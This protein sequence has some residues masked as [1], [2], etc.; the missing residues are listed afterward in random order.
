MASD[1]PPVRDEGVP[2]HEVPYRAGGPQGSLPDRKS[3]LLNAGPGTGHLP[4]SP[5]TGNPGYAYEAPQRSGRVRDDPEL[6]CAPRFRSML[7]DMPVHT[8]TTHFGNVVRYLDG[9][10]EVYRERPGLVELLSNPGIHPDH[11]EGI[12]Q[13]I[14][15]RDAIHNHEFW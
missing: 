9:H 12:R 14:A 7:R 3:A 4:G 8:Q 5:G 2:Y 6:E 13:E 1:M 15:Y 11:K 10:S